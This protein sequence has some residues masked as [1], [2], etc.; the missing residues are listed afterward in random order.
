MA[1]IT[2][3]PDFRTAGGEV[4]ELLL[5]GRYIGTMTLVYREGGRLSG[6]VQLDRQSLS[7][8][9]KEAALDAARKYVRQLADALAA[10]H[11]EVIFTCSAFDQIMAFG[12][13]RI[14]I[15][16]DGDYELGDVEPDGPDTLEM[17]D[18]EMA[19]DEMAEDEAESEDCELVIVG[20]SR[21]R[22]EY[23]VYG[24]GREWLAEAM[25]HIHGDDVVGDVFWNVMPT[26]DEVRQTAES[27]V[28]DFDPDEVSTFTFDM[29][30]NG[31]VFETIELTHED[32][33]D[34]EPAGDEEREAADDDDYS[35]VLIR[36]DGDTLTY[37]LYERSR[38]SLPIGQ[39]TVDISSRELT[40]F[41]DFREPSDSL[42]RERIGMLLMRELDKEKD[43]RSLHL[44][45]LVNNEP[46]D[47]IM[48]EPDTLH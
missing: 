17:T 28:S 13:H 26:D 4:T 31:D 32:L 41:I 33:L 14:E 6:S 7:G 34:D 22:V 5:D 25:I 44:T 19:D 8:Q 45:M 35:V 39:A 10:K 23:H 29:I 18:D 3:R 36:D 40:G 21:N 9:R 1:A 47:E 2:F 30:Y 37:D 11:C 12:P 20:E 38:G 46:I 43:Y 27:L 42:D 16:D 24:R 48:F 15:D